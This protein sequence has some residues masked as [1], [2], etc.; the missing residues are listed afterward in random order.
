MAPTHGSDTINYNLAAKKSIEKS[1]NRN[2]L[3]NKFNFSRKFGQW[4]CITYICKYFRKK[5]ES[6]ELLRKYQI[7]FSF[8]GPQSTQVKMKWWIWLK[9][10][11]AVKGAI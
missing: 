8:P 11:T 7:N 6:T 10:L 2:Q 9:N 5:R 4:K 1:R 3:C